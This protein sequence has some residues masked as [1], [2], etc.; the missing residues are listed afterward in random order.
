MNGLPYRWTMATY[1]LSQT[2]THTHGC[3][4]RSIC[5]QVHHFTLGTLAVI[6]IQRLHEG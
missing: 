4:S 2:H 6:I 5:S 1:L 3:Y